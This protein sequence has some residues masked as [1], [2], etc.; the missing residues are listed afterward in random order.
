MEEE[1][2]QIMKDHEGNIVGYE[3][4]IQVLEG[5]MERISGE[6]E[7]LEQTIIMLEEELNNAKLNN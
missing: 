2:D 4:R 1:R 5:E 3:N 7:K 6:K